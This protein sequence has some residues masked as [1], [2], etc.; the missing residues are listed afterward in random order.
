MISSITFAITTLTIYNI[1]RHK[2]IN[3]DFFDSPFASL[4]ILIFVDLV[5]YGIYYVALTV[6]SNSDILIFLIHMFNYII[7]FILLYG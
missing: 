5:Y 2:N 4:L 7:P 6:F 1:Y 3:L